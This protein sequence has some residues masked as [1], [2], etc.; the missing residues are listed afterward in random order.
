VEEKN[1]LNTFQ[2]TAHSPFFA[3]DFNVIPKGTRGYFTDSNFV[4]LTRKS[5]TEIACSHK[6]PH[7]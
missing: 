3:S 7:I 4:R 1:D 6:P 2:K 5:G